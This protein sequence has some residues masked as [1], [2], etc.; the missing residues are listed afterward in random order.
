M[1]HFPGHHNKKPAKVDPEAQKLVGKMSRE[2]LEALVLGKLAS[3]GK[4]TMADLKPAAAPPKADEDKSSDAPTNAELR[5]RHTQLARMSSTKMN[6]LHLDFAQFGTWRAS[7]KR[8]S[9]VLVA[10]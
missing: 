6:Q 2:D 7:R 3:H 10:C 9:S 8:A 4:I 5:K 1:V